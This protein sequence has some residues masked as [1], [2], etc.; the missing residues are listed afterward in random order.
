MPSNYKLPVRRSTVAHI[1]I[2]RP[3]PAE[4]GRLSDPTNTCMQ[5]ETN[6]P[7]PTFGLHL[8]P[9]RCTPDIPP[10]THTH[11][12]R[13]HAAGNLPIQTPDVQACRSDNRQV[14]FSCSN[15]SAYLYPP[16]DFVPRD[17]LNRSPESRRVSIATFQTR[18]L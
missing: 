12:H 4:S 13:D 11:A 7:Q 10:P 2:Q 15:S 5:P 9:K 8:L 3:R 14:A 16:P 6:F 17:V 1:K 18:R